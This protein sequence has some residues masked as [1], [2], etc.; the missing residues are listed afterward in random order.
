MF[1]VLKI[2]KLGAS[3]KKA[4]FNPRALFAASEPGAWYDPSDMSTLFQDSAGSTPVT[5]VGQ[6]VGLLLDK[7]KGLV[8]GPELVTNGD[9]SDGSTG[10]TVDTGWTVSGGKAEANT[11]LHAERLQRSRAGENNK[12]YVVQA[13]ITM[14]ATPHALARVSIN[15]GGVGQDLITNS[16]GPL[17][18]GQSFT[19]RGVVQPTSVNPVTFVIHVCSNLNYAMNYTVDNISIR[20][21]PGNHATQATTTKRPVLQ[22]D[23]NG[24]YYLAFDGVDD[25]MATAA[26]N[27]TATDKMS[28]WAGVTKLSDATVGT[29][30]GLG[31][32]SVAGSVFLQAPFGA[33]SPSYLF[34]ST[35]STSRWAASTA[36]PSPSTAVL[37]GISDI[38][39][40]HVSLRVNASVVATTTTDQGTGNYGNYPLYIGGQGG[41][42]YHF[43]GRLYTLIIRGAQSSLSQ[44]EA[45]EAYIKQ[46]MR[47][48]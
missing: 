25:S 13:D 44:I 46:K 32:G 30:M 33:A 37:T 10:W 31:N 3:M 45:T 35:G 28:V 24:K 38:S 27:F 48:P 26:I 40:D 14:L 39:G 2:G 7:S 15:V 21:L 42:A 8:L 36:Y 16:I 5:A 6:P 12:F 20:E 11:T 18:A 47:L 23:G 9:F 41:I 17:T 4:G 29:L 19:M 34:Q 22:Q 1:G 43:N